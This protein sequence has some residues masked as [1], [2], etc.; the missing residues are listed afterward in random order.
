MTTPLPLPPDTSEIMSNPRWPASTKV[1]G[2][3]RP[4]AVLARGLMCFGGRRAHASVCQFLLPVL[5]SAHHSYIHSGPLPLTASRCRQRPIL[6]LALL[7]AVGSGSTPLSAAAD[8]AAPTAPMS[9]TEGE[10][11]C[12]VSSVLIFLDTK[13]KQ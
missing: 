8:A 11:T 4:Q 7:P 13:K 2:A 1:L 12:P 6:L 10:L 5:L 3:A 9:S